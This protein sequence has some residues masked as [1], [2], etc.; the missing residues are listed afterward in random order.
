MQDSILQDV[1]PEQHAIYYSL[2]CNWQTFAIRPDDKRP[3]EAGWQRVPLQ[4]TISTLKATPYANLGIAVP[5]GFVVL[6]VDTKNGGPA[7]LAALESA[8]GKLPPTLTASTASGGSHK[9]FRLPHGVKIRNRAGIADGL[10]V[11]AEGGYVVAPPSTIGG[12]PYCWV[13]WVD[14]DGMTPP[15]I[16]DAP[17]WLIA[18]MQGP[19][20]NQQ[21]K[22]T[23]DQSLSIPEGMRNDTLF[24]AAATMRAKGFSATAIQSA[25]ADMNARACNPPLDAAEVAQI[26]ASAARYDRHPQPWDIFGNAAPLP[27]GADLLKPVA[28]SAAPSWSIVP[29]AANTD[30]LQPLPHFVD[31]WI[32][33]DEV[34]LLAGH[35]GTGKSY[36]ALLIAIHVA[37]GRPLGSLPTHQANVVFYSAED[38][39]RVLRS[40]LAKLCTALGVE[41]TALDGK[42]ILIDAS[43]SDPTL[44]RATDL[45]A[46]ANLAS[47]ATQHRANLIV[48]DNASD[49]FDGDEI[50]RAA[51]RGFIRSIRR[52]LAR[53]GRAVLLLAHINKVAAGN[54]RSSEDYSGSTA[55]HNSVRSRLSLSRESDDTLLVEHMKANHGP[56]AASI[57]LEWRDGVPSFANIWLDG[58]V[59]VK[60][61]NEAKQA[62][63]GVIQAIEHRGG[64]IPTAPNGSHSTYK[65]VSADAKFPKLDKMLF[66]QLMDELQDSG[67]IH[68]KTVKTPNYKLVEVFSCTP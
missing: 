68:R 7:T 3:L 22:A 15:V 32:P 19:S 59:A 60:E 4:L 1:R 57:R 54:A 10:D 27:P 17:S 42:L 5:S 39:E 55:W 46:L 38:G 13:D 20:T 12:R 24:E 6:D 43:D 65:I 2:V 23:V 36:I 50:K 40:R 58:E 25:L 62:I 8:N 28:D 56:K 14:W 53:P 63:L 41:Q 33:Q 11:R 51:V 49:V 29:L 30:S 31:R 34:T 16:A 47:L 67:Q 66:A 61:R 26:A 64:R 48:I 44:F 37:L 9:W 35:G 52:H 18:L 45:P 21:T